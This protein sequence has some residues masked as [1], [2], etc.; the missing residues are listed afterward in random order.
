MNSSVAD[1]VVGLA[2]E[3]WGGP[4][5][6]EGFL[7]S[8]RFVRSVLADERL[9]RI[10]V[11]N[12]PRSMPAMAVRPITGQRQAPIPSAKATVM[13]PVRFRSQAPTDPE[14]V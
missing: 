11:V 13:T 1:L 12:A 10:L 14:T 8:D 4:Q 2:W 5:R 6:G 9:G 3:S 7:T